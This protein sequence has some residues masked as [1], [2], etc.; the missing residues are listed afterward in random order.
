[1]LIMNLKTII[2]IGFLSAFCSTSYAQTYEI[3][4][5]AKANKNYG[6]FKKGNECVFKSIRHDIVVDEANNKVT[7]NY[8][9]VPNDGASTVGLNI[10]SKVDRAIEFKYTCTDDVWN[11]A[12][13]C[14]VLT[15][16][17]KKGMQNEMRNEMEQDA[18]EYIGR[19]KANGLIY[20]DPYLENYIY[21]LIGKIA[22][23]TL[24]DSRPGNV[25]LIILNDPEMNACMFPNGT[26]VINTGLLSTLHSEGE[27]VGVL[28]HEI[29]HFV[30]DHAVQN[31]NKA[32]SRQKRAEFWAAFA[33]GVVAAAEGYA[34]AKNP[35]YRPGAATIGVAIAASQIASQVVDRL[36]MKYNLEQEEEADEYA[37]LI[38][39]QLGY[40]KASLSSAFK[41][42]QTKLEE[43]RSKS[44]YFASY[45]HPALV[46]RI[47]NL[48]NKLIPEDKN[49][50]KMI[51]F[52]ITNT[53][54][55]RYEDRRFRQALSLVSQNINNNVGT[56]DDYILKA[57]CLLNLQ[58]TETS[59]RE[60]IDLINTA[61]AISPG[62]ISIF[63]AEIIATLRL[64]DKVTATNMLHEYIKKLDTME[65]ELSSVGSSQYW[66]YSYKYIS[67]ERAWANK[68]I[69]KLRG[70]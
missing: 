38:L 49:F 33:T 60:V 52:A 51:S 30:L 29:A 4:L 14:N 53:A 11:S 44:M 12:I 64:K 70:M 46:K 21:S 42:V 26:L 54:E 34:S 35:N 28:S 43:E 3:N 36:G 50:E 25:N 65:N 20:D 63:K 59:N 48:G 24:I 22:P 39:S 1:M 62:N 32:I 31:V 40:D 18:L 41:R 55:M 69:V 16:L 45:T 2:L 57:N 15:L 66:D 27:L 56:A 6:T 47:T 68:M 5:G 58:N 19:V 61:K 7:D 37:M 23:S 13:I 67:S 9:L 10:N 17:T 8:Y